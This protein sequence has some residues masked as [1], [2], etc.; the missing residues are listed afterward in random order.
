MNYCLCFTPNSICSAYQADD[1]R[2]TVPLTY[3]EDPVEY[4]SKMSNE[5]I[6]ALDEEFVFE[7]TGC[8]REEDRDKFQSIKVPILDADKRCLTKVSEREPTQKGSSMDNHR[9]K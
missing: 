6:I 4:P 1:N 7:T 2:Y 5:K 8:Y 3:V 9:L